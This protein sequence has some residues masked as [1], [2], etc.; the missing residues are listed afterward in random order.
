MNGGL[1][2]L[3]ILITVYPLLY[4]LFASFSNPVLLMANIGLLYKPLGFSVAGYR[5]VL[6]NPNILIGYSNTI[7]YVVLGTS[8]NLLLTILGAFVTSR[9]KFLLK[10]VLMIMIILTMYFSGGLIPRFL[11]V[12]NLGLLDSIWALLLPNA[13]STWNLII[14][15]TSF[16]GIPGELEESSHIDGANDIQLLFK[17]IVP[18]S[19]P[20][21]AVMILFYGV[22][23][24]NAWFDAMIFVSNRKLYP[25]QLFLR[26][27]LLQDSMADMND[28]A[29]MEDFFNKQLVKYSTVIVST[30]PIL[31]VYPFVQKYFVKGVMVGA[32]KG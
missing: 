26:E 29:A 10:P 23:H 13:I 28:V 5:L 9:K 25:L 8:I 19:M 15:R 27:I 1:M 2:I 20:V 6:N 4:V 24:W 17:I 32:L 12:R 30:L 31:C 14:M 7:L 18:L 21:I 3:M 11:V 22:G 16:Q